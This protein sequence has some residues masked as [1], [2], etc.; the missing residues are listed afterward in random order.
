MRN[1]GVE[2]SGV[3]DRRAFARKIA[4]DLHN[5]ISSH[6]RTEFNGQRLGTEML[7]VPTNFIDR[8]I[9]RFDEKYHRDPNFY[10]KQ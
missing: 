5:Y 6:A 9:A 2:H 10:L 1:L 3:E 7:V 4:H 8:W